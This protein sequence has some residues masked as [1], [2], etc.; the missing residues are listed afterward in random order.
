MSFLY[1]EMQRYYSK[2]NESEVI[3]LVKEKIDGNISYIDKKYL[4]LFNDI[5][6]REPCCYWNQKVYNQTFTELN[7]SCSKVNID[8]DDSIINHFIIGYGAYQ[9]ITDII[10]DLEN[11]NDNPEIK[12]RLYR[13]PT[14]ISIVEG[15]LTNLFRCILLI[16]NQTTT[17]DFSSQKKLNPICEALKSNGFDLLVKDVNVNIRNAINHGGVVF[18]V[19]AGINIIEFIYNENKKLVVLPLKVY[20]FD[21]LINKVY[22][23]A[24]GVLLG[25]AHFLNNH[26]KC[27]S[28]NRTQKSYLAFY[29]LSMEL[30]IPDVR[31][32]S[33]S[34]LEDDKQLNVDFKIVNTDRMFIIQTAIEIAMLVYAQYSDYNKYMISFSGERLQSSWIVFRN[35]DIYD[36]ITK[37]RELSDVITDIINRKSCL[38][39]NASTEEVNMQEIKYF[40]FP[41]YSSTKFKINK[42]ED[43]SID[44][45]KR[46]RAH[47]FIGDIVDKDEIL[48][49]INEAIEWLKL[50]ENPPSPTIPHK[51][52][53]MEA[54][55]LYIYVFRK[56]SRK[57]KELYPNNENFVCMVDYNIDGRTTLK[58]GGVFESIWVKLHHEKIGNIE[59]AWREGKYTIRKNIV[60][61]GRNA[62][63]ICGSGKKYKNCCL[64]KPK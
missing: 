56:D 44:D 25:L 35:D 36:M 21:E 19:K 10:N 41:N 26:S 50:V 54:D 58:N 57:N 64:N 46:L 2:N 37:K 31:C 5:I 20:E 40:R 18:K 28:V 33:I 60:K 23:T 22:D 62:P 51:Y 3:K 45:R 15:C 38:I 53:K 61:I 6:K 13:I 14:Y 12:N 34:G 55:S 48:K 9:Q 17:K 8:I 52:G 24:S 32:K 11:L 42:V 27:I 59:I 43:A 4:C 16:F 7:N 30:S 29:L 1:Q 39:W 49:I 47:L 63:C